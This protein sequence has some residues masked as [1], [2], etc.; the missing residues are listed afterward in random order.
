M[1]TEFKETADVS[2]R[3]SYLPVFEYRDPLRNG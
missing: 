2:M 1:V 3:A